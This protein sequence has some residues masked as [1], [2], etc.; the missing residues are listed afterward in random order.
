MNMGGS[1][2]AEGEKLQGAEGE[3]SFILTR[4]F[5]RR[6]L[7]DGYSVIKNAPEGSV[8]RQISS[9]LS[10][11]F[12]KNP[13]AVSPDVDLESGAKDQPV[14]TVD[15]TNLVLGSDDRRLSTQ[16]AR[17][18]S[19]SAGQSVQAL[20]TKLNQCK[21]FHFAPLRWTSP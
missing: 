10:G 7:S 18:L 5:A 4:R 3:W 6:S 2:G 11:T 16:L 19:V 8:F 15:R 20:K 1:R 21:Y 17:R 14:N 9:S 12:G 13:T